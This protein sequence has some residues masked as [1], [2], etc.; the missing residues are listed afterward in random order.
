MKYLIICI[1]LISSFFG[2]SQSFPNPATLS[3]GQGAIGTFDPIWQVS[4]WFTSS[5]PNPMGLTYTP[6][7]INNNC[8]PGAWV[9]PASLPAPVNNGNWITG[10]DANCA[11]NTADGYKYFRLTLNLPP[12]CNGNSIA[13]SGNY[14]LYLTGYV[15]NSITDVFVNGTAIGI[16]GGSYSTGSQ[17]NIAIPGPWIPGINYV[18]IQIYNI[19]NGSGN[20]YGLLL[21][22]NSSALTNADTDGDGISD[23]NDLCPCEAGLASNGCPPPITPNTQICLG[24]STLITVTGG[25]SYLWSNGSQN[26]SIVV[27]PTASTTYTV[28]VQNTNGTITS[29]QSSVA[30]LPVD[31]SYFQ[32]VICDGSEYFFSNNIYDLPGTYSI[33][34]TASNGCDSILIL[35]LDVLPPSTF[36]TFITSCENYTWNGQTYTNSGQ[37][38]YQTI[39]S[40][41]CDSIAILNLTINLNN[42]SVT[43]VTACDSYAWNGQ[44]FTSNGLYSFQTINASG[45]DS[46]AIIDLIILNSS[47]SYQSI[48]ACESFYWSASGTTYTISGQYTASLI[49]SAGCDSLLTIDLILNNYTSGVDVILACE[50]Y[51][52]ID[53]VTYTSSTS[54]PTYILA[55]SSGCD[56]L[57]TLELTINIPTSSSTS[58]AACNNYNWNGQ[59]Y[60]SSGQYM[61]QTIN[62][63]G[64][65]STAVLN[66]TVNLSNGYVA[67][68]S[69]C[70]SYSW[71]GQNYTTSGQY[72]YQTVNS[73]GCDSMLILNLELSPNLSTS[74]TIWVCELSETTT[75]VQNYLSATGCDSIHTIYYILLP[76]AERAQA[77]FSCEPDQIVSLPSAG[78]QLTNQ[79]LQASGFLWNFG[80]TVSWT[81]EFEPSYTY[82]EIGQFVIT[83]I[84]NNGYNCPDT[85]IHQI[86]VKEDLFL[87]VPNAFTPDGD[88]L[89]NLFLP[90]VSGDFDPYDFQFLIFNRWGQIVFESKN[91]EVGWDGRYGES[92]APNGVYTWIV[93]IKSRS[94]DRVSNY[95]GHVLLT[96]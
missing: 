2:I 73:L 12:D 43:T 34:E 60:T 10:N 37:Y 62:T 5:P 29:L 82:T 25:D 20:P 41:G 39:N 14:I 48:M 76:D 63:L 44:I 91:N 70:D 74:E 68:V 79:S 6:A 40:L 53:G 55:N 13:I 50:S 36:E 22:A 46:T 75:I 81:N 17:L 11:N 51:T 72:S 9:D 47:Q 96:R 84:A 24:E 42:T 90:I 86:I 8:A 88:E 93:K 67:N 16:S 7:L 94:N 31:T 23:I 52:W 61:Y 15:D 71:N 30:V 18:D 33:T 58:V 83:L 78:I 4:P 3:T 92:Y 1:S 21:V 69:A 87:Y 27:S 57:V 45:C 35:E 49:N 28:N 54:V 64:C 89:N 77:L 32:A 26:D 85:A 66:L 80:E 56:S 19:P 65:D 38:S 95:N 59:T